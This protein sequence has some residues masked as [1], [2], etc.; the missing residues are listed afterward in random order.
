MFFIGLYLVLLAYSQTCYMIL[1]VVTKATVRLVWL[2]EGAPPILH[3][4]D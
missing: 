1:A 2:I 3:A 4:F